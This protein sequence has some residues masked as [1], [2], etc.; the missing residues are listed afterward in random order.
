[1]YTNE[2]MVRKIL[3]CLPKNKWGPKVTV[4]KEAQDLQNIAQDDLLG[5]LLT[6][7]IHLKEDEDEVQ[8]KRGVAFMTITAELQSSK[9]ESTE[10]V[11]DSMTMIA[12]GLKTMFKS[13]RF[14]PKKFYKKGSSSKKTLKGNKFSATKNETELSPCFGCGLL[15]RMVKDCPIIQKKAEKMNQRAKKEKEPK[16]AMIAAWSCSNSS[17]SDNKEEKMENLCFMANE[18]L[19][20]E[21]KT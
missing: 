21:D 1:M 19:I 6:H 5:K 15:G 17:D 11:E 4:F 9:D 20:Q 13:R 12:R 3:R 18:D 14:D 2:E 8:P 7:E 16:R 10:S